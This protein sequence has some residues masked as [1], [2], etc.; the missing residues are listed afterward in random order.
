M[1]DGH[2]A[3]LEEDAPAHDPTV[4]PRAQYELVRTLLGVAM[5]AVAALTIAV[6][7]LA[8]SGHEASGQRSAEAAGLYPINYGGFSPN[9]GRPES[10]PLPR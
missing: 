10:A 2:D 3:V 9:T 1:E 8:N 4:V 5:T 6:L 7:I